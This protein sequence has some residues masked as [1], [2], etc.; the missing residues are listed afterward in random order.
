MYTWGTG[1]N[2]ELGNGNNTSCNNPILIN[3]FK[4]F[5]ICK[6]SCGNNYTSGLDCNYFIINI[7][8]FNFFY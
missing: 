7:K 5:F 2:G 4:K 1:K 6:I 3:S 8:I